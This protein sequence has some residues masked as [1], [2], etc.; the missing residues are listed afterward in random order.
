[1]LTTRPSATPC[2]SFTSRWAALIG[3]QKQ[4]GA[5]LRRVSQRITTRSLD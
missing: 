4:A 3:R 1:L 2:S 5:Q